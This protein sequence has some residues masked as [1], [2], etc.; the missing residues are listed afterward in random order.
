MGW[1]FWCGA[2][3][4]GCSTQKIW[5]SGIGLSAWLV[6]LYDNPGV[7]GNNPAKDKLRD[8]LFAEAPRNILDLG[9]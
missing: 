2:T 1:D 7:P 9:M 3:L 4:M 6:H 8:A 5:D